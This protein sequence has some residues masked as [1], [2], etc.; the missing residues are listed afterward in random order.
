MSQLNKKNLLLLS[1]VIKEEDVDYNYIF[2]AIDKLEEDRSDKEKKIVKLILNVKK[3][4]KDEEIEK[5][6]EQIKEIFPK[7]K[8]PSGKY[9]RGNIKNISKNVKWFLKEYSYDD[10]VVIKAT[11]KYVEEFKSKEYLYMHTA[12]YFV[13]KS[14]HGTKQSVLADWCESII[15]DHDKNDNTFRSNFQTKVV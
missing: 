13:C 11:K 6:A 14:I 10:E 1:S 15:E 4:S 12:A 5:L 2:H 8:L 3:E 7:I 9:A